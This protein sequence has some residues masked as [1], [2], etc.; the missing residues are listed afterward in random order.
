LIIVTDFS[1]KP[2]RAAGIAMCLA[3]IEN[4]LALNFIEVQGNLRQ[5]YNG[6]RAL[7]GK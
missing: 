3:V 2:L 1:G 4:G 7:A 6:M 5:A